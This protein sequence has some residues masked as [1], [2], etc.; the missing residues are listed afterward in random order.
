MEKRRLARDD[1]ALHREAVVAEDVP[2]VDAAEL[3]VGVDERRP[4]VGPGPGAD[5]SRL[6]TCTIDRFQNSVS[7][8]P[9]GSMISSPRYVVGWP[10]SA[11]ST[12]LRF[13]G[14]LARNWSA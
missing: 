9:F 8:T 7:S 1:L 12:Q 10:W 4:G 5:P 13:A 3:A 2:G 11:S 14:R 6:S